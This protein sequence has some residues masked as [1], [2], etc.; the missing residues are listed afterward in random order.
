MAKLTDLQRKQ[1]I[2]DRVGGMSIRALAAKY[3]VST[4]TV[5][6]TLKTDTK[7]TQKL[8]DK[9]EQNTQSVIAYMEEQKEAVCDTIGKLLGAIGS[10]AK[11]AA[12]PINQLATAMG[13]LIDK[14]TASEYAGKSAGAENNLLDVIEKAAE[15]YG[16]KEKTDEIRDV[17][18][19]AADNND[20]V[21]NT[22][23]GEI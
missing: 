9:K 1:L 3:K 2:A 18:P 4:T 6:A 20:M 16:G 22:E 15:E 10:D 11:I 12:A 7:L 21:E 8:T 17:Q 23:D 5:Q 14:F 13:I 19:E